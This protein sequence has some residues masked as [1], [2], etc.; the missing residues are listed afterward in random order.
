MGWNKTMTIHFSQS[1]N[2][3]ILIDGI[4]L[5]SPINFLFSELYNFHLPNTNFKPYQVNIFT[6]IKCNMLR[7]HFFIHQVLFKTRFCLN[8]EAYKAT[9]VFNNVIVNF[10]I[11]TLCDLFPSELSN[12]TNTTAAVDVIKNLSI[13]FDDEQGRPSRCYMYDVDY[14]QVYQVN[15]KAFHALV[16]WCTYYKPR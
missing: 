16:G 5:R 11:L 12:L 10:W 9:S 7:V 14:A 6:K 13:P 8:I 3:A 4:M 2:T 15:S 1:S